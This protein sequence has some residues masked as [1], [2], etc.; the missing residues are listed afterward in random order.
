MEKK[1]NA[2]GVTSLVLG[3][4][5]FLTGFILIGIVFDIIAII[6]GL[7]AIISKKQKSGLGK[8][9][10]VIALCSII[11]V[12]IL[13]TVFSFNSNDSGSI[14]NEQSSE[15][16]SGIA[17]SDFTIT[18]YSFHDGVDNTMY[19]MVV[20][21][22]S[23]ETVDISG[24]TTALDSTNKKVG[25]CEDE[26]YAIAPSESACLQFYYDTE[27]A[28]SFK[29]SIDYKKS[30]YSSTTSLLNFEE[31][32]NENNVVV[33]CTNNANKTAT[34]IKASIIFFNGNVAVS[35]DKTYI[36]DDNNELKAGENNSAEL[37]SYQKF[38]NY[39]IFY[40]AR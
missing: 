24:D 37:D 1:G 14:T 39:K 31:S 23:N 11:L 8:A 12:A 19:V 36:G 6:F 5:G 29:Y 25:V 10:L 7:I 21:N 30:S 34:N 16:S 20:K 3:I 2:F 26:C 9:G 13:G 38:D 28:A 18:E 33:T 22:N 27:N 4:V 15:T 17:D 32:Q 40:S 35:C